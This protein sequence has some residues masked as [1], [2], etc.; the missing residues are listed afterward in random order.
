MDMNKCDCIF[1]FL[2]YSTCVYFIFLPNYKTNIIGLILLIAHIYRDIVQFKK[3]Y[4]WT[5]Y[6]ALILALILI[7]EGY[8]MYN[9]VVFIV[10]IIIFI[11]HS[12]QLL[13]DD[14]RYYY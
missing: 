8:Y 1:R 14:D 2:V 9:I 7:Y 5:E 4:L 3:W 10:G 11:G 12:R 6:F 13:Y